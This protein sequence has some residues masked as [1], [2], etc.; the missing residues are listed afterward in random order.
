MEEIGNDAL[1]DPM[2]E[3]LPNSDPLIDPAIDECKK[4]GYRAD[5]SRGEVDATRNQPKS[6]LEL[7]RRSWII[8]AINTLSQLSYL[9]AATSLSELLLYQECRASGLGKGS[10][11]RTNNDAQ[12]VAARRLAIIGAVAGTSNFVTVSLI[13]Q[14]CQCRGRRPALVVGCAGLCL[15]M[16]HI[17]LVNSVNH[18]GLFLAG[19]AIFSLGGGT[20][21]VQSCV[22]TVVADHTAGEPPK[23]IAYL[24]GLLEA[25]SSL[26][27][28]GGPLLGH[29][30]GQSMGFETVFFLAGIIY[31]ICGLL[32]L[33]FVRETIPEQAPISL[34]RANPFF[35]LWFLL[36]PSGY[37][38]KLAAIQALTFM[39]A[40]G[41]FGMVPLYFSKH[42]NMETIQLGL[43]MTEFCASMTIGLVFLLPRLQRSMSSRAL[44]RLGLLATSALTC[45][46]ALITASWQ[47]FVL[48]GLFLCNGFSYPLVRSLVVEYFGRELH[49]TALA[50]LGSVAIA[51][52]LVTNVFFPTV[53][54][55]TQQ[56]PVPGAVFLIGG[57]LTLLGGVLAWLLPEAPPKAPPTSALLGD[58]LNQASRG[59][60][61]AVVASY[62]RQRLSSGGVM[63]VSI[64]SVGSLD[65]SRPRSPLLQVV[66]NTA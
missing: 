31:G 21:A 53:Y 56:G 43:F 32:I 47:A 17:S 4:I 6:K 34:R 40:I 10:D 39:G 7:L 9:M 13:G 59:D 44:I 37:T 42:F 49:G 14:L 51:T 23:T 26:G 54:G 12:K 63:Y 20:V 45:S 1:N 66:D 5:Q 30:L 50:A 33:I 16:F 22:F 24:F 64:G 27:F 35:G 60:D 25:A 55:A 2:H 58:S 29:G 41:A 36:S 65:G 46:I 8:M 3:V 11:C 15:Y 19:A 48:G 18:F 52:T 28:I 38:A 57:S 62:S 61:N